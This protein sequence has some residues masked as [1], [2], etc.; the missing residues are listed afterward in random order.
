MTVFL[1]L[2]CS[3]LGFVTLTITVAPL[4]KFHTR[5]GNFSNDSVNYDTSKSLLSKNLSVNN[6]YSVSA[7][8]RNV[9][10]KHNA[11]I[12]S[13]FSQN[14]SAV[15]N[16]S[17][18]ATVRETSKTAG[19]SIVSNDSSSVVK[20]D[21][22]LKPTSSRNSSTSVANGTKSTTPLKSVSA[23]ETKKATPPKSGTMVKNTEVKPDKV[24]VT[25]MS[26]RL[27]EKGFFRD[28]ILPSISC[29]GRNIELILCVPVKRD[30]AA[31]REVIRLTWGSY[32][33]YG[34]RPGGNTTT[35][36]DGGAGEIILVFFIGSSSLVSSKAEQ[37]K[38]AEEAK[39]FGD[40]YQADFIDTYENLTLKSISILKFVSSLCP[41]A[42]YVAKIDDDM[43]VNIPLLLKELQAVTKKLSHG[44]NNS[45]NIPP[46]AYGVLFKKAIV[47]RDKKSKWFT[48]PEVYK[49]K[50]YPT[51]LSGTTYAMSGTAA[52]RLYEATLKVPVFWM[53]DIYV[54]GMCSIVAKV[55]LT[56]NNN[57]C[58]IAKR[59]PTGCAFQNAISGHQY[60]ASE[61]ITIHT[62]LHSPSLKC[63]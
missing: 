16:R 6:N 20:P 9:S 23:P 62:Q 49:P 58:T 22:S 43:Y 25:S 34:G 40:I 57:L 19:A 63:K 11:P 5:L 50:W 15:S 26:G 1:C 28:V 10:K 29:S 39:I 2:V 55:S 36:K 35:G 59:K 27:V 31:T 37:D 38:I 45:I 54:T 8:L 33:K 13:T 32:G 47:I 48:S 24:P 21:T 41:N 3:V 61:L 53:E 60:T 12:A 42:R 7:L 17:T 51:Y 4:E 18:P 30:N 52:L 56:G 14:V 46:F 44:K